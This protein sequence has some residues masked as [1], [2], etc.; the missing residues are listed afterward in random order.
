MEFREGDPVM[1]WTYGLGKV[2]KLEERALSGKKAFYYSVKIGDLTVWVPADDNLKKRLRRPTSHDGFNKLLTILK[3][4][5]EPLPEDRQERKIKLVEMLKDGRAESLCRVIRDLTNFRQI[6][7]LNENDQALM[8]RAQHA[9][10][11]E[12]GFALSVTPAQAESEMQHLL[13]VSSPGA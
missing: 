5:G 3:G 7:S 13:S 4:P 1:H 8:K 10:V 9:L 6:R 11:G 12:W 2:I